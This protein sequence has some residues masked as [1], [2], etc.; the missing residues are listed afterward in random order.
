MAELAE[1]K[2]KYTAAIAVTM[3]LASL[4]DGALAISSAI[5]YATLRLLGDWIQLA[6][7]SGTGVSVDGVVYVYAIASLDGSLYPVNADN[8]KLV[9]IGRIA[10]NADGTVF[11]SVPMSIKDAFRGDAPPPYV[12]IVV[13]NSSGAAFDGTEGNHTKLRLGTTIAAEG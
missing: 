11:I 8:Q 6:I 7:K 4:A 5:D 9:P 1:Y 10:M 13:L 3:T 12:Q 2:P